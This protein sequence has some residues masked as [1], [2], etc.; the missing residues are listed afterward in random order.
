MNLY[1]ELLTTHAKEISEF[2]I[3]FAFTDEQFEQG[4]K[5]LGLQTDEIKKLISI[6]IGGFC[7]EEDQ[8][9]FMSL[10]IKHVE[11]FENALS[12]DKT[13]ELFITDM[14]LYELAHN[15]YLDSHEITKTLES[16]ALSLDAI[17]NSKSLSTGLMNALKKVV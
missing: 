5:M 1:E 3:F 9:G 8:E 7:R 2:P 15:E 6:D 14:F 17:H 10:I 13:G 11:E 4:V 12:G 16:L